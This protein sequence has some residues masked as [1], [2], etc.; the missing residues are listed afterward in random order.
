MGLAET[1]QN[2][3]GWALSI[4]VLPNSIFAL[5]DFSLLGNF[6][7]WHAFTVLSPVTAIMLV[8]SIL[9]TAFFDGMGT[10]YAI[11]K[12]AGLVDKDGNP[13]ASKRIF[14]IDSLGSLSGGLCSISP[15][16][17]FVESSAGIAE[18]AKTGLASVITG[19]CFLLT[20]FLTPLITA[21]PMEAVAPAL[22]FVGYL[23]IKEMTK[24]NWSAPDITIPAFLIIISIPFTYSITNGI[25][26]GF[27]T[28]V[29]MKIAKG[30]SKEIH[31]LLWV[32]S[33]IFLIYFLQAGVTQLLNTII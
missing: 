1:D 24:L 21:V 14:I 12:E 13:I 22:I 20:T 9:L 10:M 31:P 8:F 6:N 15:N 7:I 19:I 33:A 27:I 28:Y 2:A 3:V 5:P 32:V 18:G 30:K 25:G 11:S 23:M 4:P 16:T 17:I 26:I 29:V